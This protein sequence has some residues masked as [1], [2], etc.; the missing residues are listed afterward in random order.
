ML[1]WGIYHVTLRYDE[2]W[3]RFS[4]NT[5]VVGGVVASASEPENYT[6]YGM[7]A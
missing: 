1:T 3:D 2:A 5:N 7:G 6:I 4:T